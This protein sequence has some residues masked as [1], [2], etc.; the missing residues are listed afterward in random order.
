MTKL[1]DFSKDPIT[2]SRIDSWSTAENSLDAG[3]GQPNGT[4]FVPAEVCNTQSRYM[5]MIHMHS[6]QVDTC[7]TEPPRKRLL[8][9]F[10][11]V[12]SA[13]IFTL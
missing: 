6:F 4:Q 9:D 12:R 11:F 1:V 3:A 10:L 8:V 2:L 13:F 7:L 5:T